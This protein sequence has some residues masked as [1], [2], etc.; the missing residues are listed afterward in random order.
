MID[1]QYQAWGNALG[2][3]V[4]PVHDRSFLSG[5]NCNASLLEDGTSYATVGQLRIFETD[6]VDRF[7]QPKTSQTNGFSV[8]Q[9]YYWG[10]SGSIPQIVSGA[11]T[12]SDN[13]ID[14][15]AN[16]ISAVGGLGDDGFCIITESVDWNTTDITLR[17][18]NGTVT[19]L[20]ASGFDKSGLL[21]TS[22]NGHVAQRTLSGGTVYQ[23]PTGSLETLPLAFRRNGA[24][25]YTAV[26]DYGDILTYDQLASSSADPD[27]LGRKFIDPASGRT[28][29]A[30]CRITDSS[31]PSGWSGVDVHA[32]GNTMPLATQQLLAAQS[33]AGYPPSPDQARF[34]LLGGTAFKD[35]KQYPVLLVQVEIMEVI[36]D[37]IAGVEV[38]KLPSPYYGGEIAPPYDPENPCAGGKGFPNNPMQM[39][40]R[41]DGNAYLKMRVKIHGF[42]D[43]Q[44]PDK[45]LVGM[46]VV[47][48]RNLIIEAETRG[49]IKPVQYPALTYLS[50]D[51]LAE[52]ALTLPRYEAV[53]GWDEN[54]DGELQTAEVSGTFQKTPLIDSSGD[55]SEINMQFVDLIRIA[56][57]LHRDTCT[58]FLY[59]ATVAS[60]GFAYTED[61]LASFVTGD[62]T[63]VTSNSH[64][65]EVATTISASEI[66]H[67]VGL[68]F[69]TAGIGNSHEFIFDED[70]EM[71]EDAYDSQVLR[72]FFTDLAVEKLQ[73][74]IQAAP[75]NPGEHSNYF[76]EIPTGST[77]CFPGFYENYFVQPPTASSRL[78][79][80][81]KKA[82]ISGGVDLRINRYYTDAT[83][84]AQKL[85]IYCEQYVGEIT[86][87]YDFVNSTDI[88]P[89]SAA[90]IQARSPGSSA[91]GRP[92]R[93]KALLNSVLSPPRILII[94]L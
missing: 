32:L 72:D 12:L 8:T 61:L 64:A 7:G 67:P 20:I 89:R 25:Y 9:W 42:S 35:G 55:P 24:G 51:P 47:E 82:K 91:V 80:S 63:H 23:F 88:L 22:R 83:Q 48:H 81:L 16:F 14:H 46:R 43:D 76:A 36:S 71:S 1:A 5:S 86:D 73:E 75:E 44:V 37:Q 45:L 21:A 17:A 93:T 70:S 50:F 68:A 3:S 34:P 49:A 30:T 74:I 66:S 27:I 2:W 41:D 10:L 52:V 69:S 90:I 29:R 58:A 77:L 33:P 28:S 18:K 65:T 60:V 38:N 94:N 39:G 13:Y 78:F 53:Y 6:Y 40:T 11:A 87:V 19:N 31:I 56:T 4:I 85:E 92:S 59:A 84:T 54:G 62:K 15:K 26:N 79:F 57:P